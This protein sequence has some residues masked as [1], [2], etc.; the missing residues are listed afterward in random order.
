MGKEVDISS[1]NSSKNSPEKEKEKEKEKKPSIP[2]YKLF[3]YASFEDT[4]LIISGI[5]CSAAVG[6]LQPTVIIFFGRYLQDITTAIS[7]NPVSEGQ[8]VDYSSATMPTILSF[9]YMAV[10]V[11]VASYVAQTLWISSGQRQTRRIRLL[12][13]HSVLRQDMTWFDKSEEGSLITRLAADTQLIREGISEKFGL[14]ILSIAQ[15]IGG[16]IVGFTSSWL[17]SLVILATF[18][19]FILA[20]VLMGVFVT[21]Y[22]AKVQDA[23][24]DAGKVAEQA[25]SGIRTVQAFTL[26]S[27]FVAI[28]TKELEKARIAGFK[29]SA[30]LAFST[31]FFIFVFFSTYALSLWYGSTLVIQG[32]ITGSQVIIAFFGIIYGAVGLVMLPNYLTAITTACGAAHSIYATIDR[33]P[34]IDSD[35]KSSQNLPDD[36]AADIQF[37]NIS[38]NYP[39]RP[40]IQ[41]LNKLNLH[42]K[43]GSTVALVGASGRKIDHHAVITTFL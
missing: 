30:I 10:G 8:T 34:N 41:I 23:Y 39:T 7:L 14:F 43:N 3:K 38:F 27:R 1:N 20:A 32:R 33:I 36:Y 16:I 40:D 18:P 26:Q 35:Q 21:K 31:G 12:Y 24:A 42:V 29:R 22:T 9:V 37:K 28:Y 4:L 2:I 19:I 17:L 15:F 13:F 5:I 6:V 25:F 11:L